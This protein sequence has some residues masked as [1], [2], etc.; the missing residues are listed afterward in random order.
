MNFDSTVTRESMSLPGVSFTVRRLNQIERAR[1]DFSIADETL[2]IAEL[3]TR[4]AQLNPGEEKR[5][6]PDEAAEVGRINQEL[7]FLVNMHL[8]PSA[9]R[10]G[11]V[12]IDGLQIDGEEATTEILIAR[13][14]RELVEEVWQA[15]QE[16]A[17][18]GDEER[19]NSQSP[20]ILP[21]RA[22]GGESSTSAERAI[23]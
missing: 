19:K 21:I 5:L 13:G 9:I 16:S 12:S 23:A 1:R 11:L 6:S 17:G 2:K 22:D 20:T 4:H 10:A 3:I 7:D 8:K 14:P 18:L 15:C